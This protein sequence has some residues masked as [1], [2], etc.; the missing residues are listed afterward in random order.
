MNI[1]NRAIEWSQN[2]TGN[3]KVMLRV[4]MRSGKT[5]TGQVIDCNNGVLILYLYPNER[6]RRHEFF[7]IDHIETVFPIV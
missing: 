7:A 2:T 1:V 3:P 5:E 6:Q 4:T